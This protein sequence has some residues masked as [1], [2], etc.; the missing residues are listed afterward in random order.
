MAHGEC[1]ICIL[2]FAHYLLYNIHNLLLP[3]LPNMIR[4]KGNET[5]KFGQLIEYNFI[6][7]FLKNHENEAGRVVPDLFLFFEI[8][9]YEDKASS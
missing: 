3:I 6:Y 9:L 5:M 7:I 2:L 4:I 1:I 8:V